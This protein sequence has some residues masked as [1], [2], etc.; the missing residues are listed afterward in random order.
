METILDGIGEMKE[1]REAQEIWLEKIIISQKHKK[2]RQDKD[3]IIIYINRRAKE[4][5]LCF[6]EKGI[7]HE[8][9]RASFALDGQIEPQVNEKGIER[10]AIRNE[11]K[12]RFLKELP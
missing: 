11:Q 2:N 3:T 8:I 1:T 4:V 10:W 9:G 7:E 5:I 12:R 6:T